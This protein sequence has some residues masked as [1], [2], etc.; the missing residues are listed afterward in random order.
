MLSWIQQYKKFHGV[1]PEKLF[2][3]QY[4][5]PDDL[6][7]EGRGVTI[8]Y[9]IVE[10][11]SSKEG[12]YVHDFKEGVKVWRRTRKNERPDKVINPDSFPKNLMV[13][14]FWLGMSYEDEDEDMR[15]ALGSRNKLLCTNLSGKKLYVINK[16]TKVV[17]Y[18]I[19]GGRM[20]VTDWIRN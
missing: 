11:N 19:Y 3:G 14:G 6:V 9:G 4:D 15:E 2:E 17:E 7:L 12:R 5:V 20:H 18:V 10:H 16:R 13:L 1:E 8:G